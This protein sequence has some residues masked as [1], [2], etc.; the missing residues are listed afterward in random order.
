VTK[1]A[2][3]SSSLVPVLIVLAIR[4]SGSHC[5]A[6][7]AL[8]VIGVVLGAF[9]FGVLQARR[10]IAAQPFTVKTIRD[11]SQQI[12]AYLLTY[13]FPFLFPSVVGWRDVAA[14]LA[15]ALLVLILLF[16]TDLALVNPLLL[17]VG[18]HLY[19]MTT[20][21]EKSLILVAKAK[22]SPGQTILAVRLSDTTYKLES[23]QA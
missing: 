6:A 7:V 19:S 3:L 11:E 23:I 17:A 8:V 22:P 18:F 4:L 9:L 15:F 21:S 12:P 1:F 16:R 20:N 10:R 13:V 14:C 5:H 2:L